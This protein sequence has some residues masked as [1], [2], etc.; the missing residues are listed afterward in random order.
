MQSTG[1]APSAKDK[2]DALAKVTSHKLK[3]M[4]KSKF[5]NSVDPDDTAHYD[6]SDY[7]TAHHDPSE[8]TLVALNFIFNTAGGRER[9]GVWR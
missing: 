6:T 1:A 8:S 4:H 7:K 2:I 3:S 5:A 9:R